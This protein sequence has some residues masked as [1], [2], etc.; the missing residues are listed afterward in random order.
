MNKKEIDQQL[1]K[2]DKA[3]AESD[4]KAEVMDLEMEKAALED[5][6]EGD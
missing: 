2:I 3:I 6:K 5:I 1:E 4:Q